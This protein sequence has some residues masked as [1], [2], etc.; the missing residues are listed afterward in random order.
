[1][2]ES[3]IN[4]FDDLPGA[5]EYLERR[6]QMLTRHD[7]ERG[8]LAERQMAEIAAY[9]RGLHGEC[10]RGADGTTTGGGRAM[11]SE[12]L[13][14]GCDETCRRA[15]EFGWHTPI[16][17]LGEPTD[18]SLAEILEADKHPELADR[19]RRELDAIKRASVRW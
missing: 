4:R 16:A 10:Q 1:M 9:D 11:S 3:S 2:N 12:N 17:P 13:P 5:A 8:E 15:A 14:V 7:R 19:L 6:R 18:K